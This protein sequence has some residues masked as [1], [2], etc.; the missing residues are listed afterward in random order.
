M[1]QIFSEAF[2]HKLFF[3]TFKNVFIL[4]FKVDFE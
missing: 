3:K 4:V 2:F 1:I